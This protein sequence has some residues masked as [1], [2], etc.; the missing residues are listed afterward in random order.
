MEEDLCSSAP[1]ESDLALA[2]KKPSTGHE[3]QIGPPSEGFTEML[4]VLHMYYTTPLT[5]SL[6][7]LYLVMYV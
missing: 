5:I 2:S 6:H 3:N 4:V 7:I 1:A